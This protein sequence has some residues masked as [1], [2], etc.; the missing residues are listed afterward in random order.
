MTTATQ[1][2]NASALPTDHEARLIAICR[3]LGSVPDERRQLSHIARQTGAR[4]SQAFAFVSELVAR[5]WVERSA[6]G[7]HNLTEIGRRCYGRR[8]LITG[9]PAR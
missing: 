5:G 4:T 1:Q 6:D 8:E 2:T 7:W 3:Y 9:G